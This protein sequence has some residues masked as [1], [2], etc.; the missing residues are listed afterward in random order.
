MVCRRVK[1]IIWGTL[2]LYSD[3]W[4][5][6]VLATS[7][8]LMW[9]PMRKVL[10][11]C[12][13]QKMNRTP[14]YLH[15]QM[16]SIEE[17]T[18]PNV[19]NMQVAKVGCVEA[20]VVELGGLREFHKWVV[21][22]CASI[23][24]TW[25][26]SRPLRWGKNELWHLKQSAWN[27][28]LVQSCLWCILSFPSF[29]LTILAQHPITSHSACHINENL[30]CNI[31]FQ[32]LT[33]E[34]IEKT[35]A[36]VF[37]TNSYPFH[38]ESL[39][40]CFELSCARK[41]AFLFQPATSF[42][43]KY[44]S[45]IFCGQINLIYCEKKPSFQF[46]FEFETQIEK[47]FA[48][49]CLFFFFVQFKLEIFLWIPYCGGNHNMASDFGPNGKIRSSSIFPAPNFFPYMA[50]EAIP[51]IKS[52]KQTSGKAYFD[53]Q[54]KAP[55]TTIYFLGRSLPYYMMG[56][57]AGPGCFASQNAQGL[58]TTD[59]RDSKGASL[60]AMGSELSGV[61]FLMGTRRNTITEKKEMRKERSMPSLGHDDNSNIPRPRAHA[62]ITTTKNKRKNKQRE[63]ERKQVREIHIGYHTYLESVV[64]GARALDRGGGNFN[65]RPAFSSINNKERRTGRFSKRIMIKAILLELVVK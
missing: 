22:C 15:D 35:C 63:E 47:G 2:I 33:F 53:P 41:Y 59:E 28:P 12:W 1:K 61:V 25:P 7:Y 34:N 19:H 43:P 4:S 32:L 6:E 9:E 14:D 60:T 10:R 30:L 29:P 13:I 50:T 11:V 65:Q 5:S 57:E 40:T 26:L 27:S 16:N 17:I 42:W 21:W 58:R 18:I 36:F 20:V 24:C 37:Q 39:T 64:R 23:I 49:F 31:S 38:G 54:E 3:Q 8:D 48:P 45:H 51:I 56:L 44:K 46:I 52:E 55:Q 62:H